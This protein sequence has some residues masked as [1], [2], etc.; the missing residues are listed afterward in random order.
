[1]E[2]ITGTHQFMNSNSLGSKWAGRYSYD[3]F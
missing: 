1:V 2:V 3:K